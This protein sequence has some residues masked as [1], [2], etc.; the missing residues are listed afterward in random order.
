MS[1]CLLRCVEPRHSQTTTPTPNQTYRLLSTY[2]AIYLATTP[3]YVQGGPKS[4]PPNFMTSQF[5]QM[6][7]GEEASN[8]TRWSKTT[9]FSAIGVRIFG[10]FRNNANIIIQ[11]YLVLHWLSTD[12]K[13]ITL[14]NLKWPFYVCDDDRFAHFCG[15]I[16]LF[17]LCHV[18][19]CLCI[20]KLN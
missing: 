4:K 20:I 5:H 13:R 16:T 18:P 15:R 12:P 7:T 8:D 17:L 6:F 2:T 1:D 3:G 9:F 19:C 14:N 10:S 11:Y